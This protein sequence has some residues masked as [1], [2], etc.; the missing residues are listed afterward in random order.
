MFRDMISPQEPWASGGQ[1]QPLRQMGVS[2]SPRKIIY[3]ISR[4]LA[5]EIYPLL[6]VPWKP[7]SSLLVITTAKRISI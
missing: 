4:L 3:R 5:V 6:P 2:E 1:M 7:V